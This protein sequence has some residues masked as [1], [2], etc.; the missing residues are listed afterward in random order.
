M[1]PRQKSDSPPPQS[2][3]GPPSTFPGIWKYPTGFG[4]A[5]RTANDWMNSEKL[6]FVY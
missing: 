6:L 2:S 5:F 3:P 1:A 4:E